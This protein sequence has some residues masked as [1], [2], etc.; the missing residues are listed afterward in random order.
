M[1]RDI[2]YSRFI[3]CIEHGNLHGMKICVKEGV[4]VRK[5]DDHG[6]ITAAYHG[7]LEIVKY[8]HELGLCKRNKEKMHC[9]ITRGHYDIVRYFVENGSHDLNE[10]LNLIL[11]WNYHVPKEIIKYLFDKGARYSPHYS[12]L[13]DCAK[14]VEYYEY[15]LYLESVRINIRRYIKE[16]YD[17]GEK[18]KFQILLEYFRE[19]FE[20]LELLA[21]ELNVPYVNNDDIYPNLQAHLILVN[22]NG[23]PLIRDF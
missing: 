1:D 21:E 22:C 14:R 12:V 18:N 5:W 2:L 19:D 13:Q 3:K 16:F 20:K 10:I 6:M 11:A 9:A 15:L 23:A 4:N 8:L 7:N 17:N